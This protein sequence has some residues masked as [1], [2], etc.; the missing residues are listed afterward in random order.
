MASSEPA[1]SRQKIDERVD[2]LDTLFTHLEK[3]A[4]DLDDVV[5]DGHQR[6]ENLSDQIQDLQ[7][8]VKQ[9]P[10]TAGDDKND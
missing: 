7:R 4:Q 1:A 3:T 2:K 5:I 9:G 6:L 8:R 10:E